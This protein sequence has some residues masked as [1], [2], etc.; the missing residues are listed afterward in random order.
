MQVQSTH[1]PNR[2]SLLAA[3]G[4]LVPVSDSVAFAS[5]A[6]RWIPLR[7]SAAAAGPCS[8][9]SRAWSCSGS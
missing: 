2:I 1:D 5:I 7:G 9:S 8:S 3:G 6:L 4:A